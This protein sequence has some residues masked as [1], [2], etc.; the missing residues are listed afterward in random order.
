MSIRCYKYFA[1][2]ASAAD[3]AALHHQ[4][5]LA[6]DYRRVLVDIENRQRA[7]LRA[8]WA[9]PMRDIPIAERKAWRDAGGNAVI[10]AWTASDE[11]KTWR[12]TIQKAGFATCK[13]AYNAA[14]A[15]GLAW[16]TRLAVGEAVDH[17]RRTTDWVD[18]LRNT[19][20]NRVAVQIQLTKPLSGLNVVGGEDTRLQIGSEPYALGAT[21]DGFRVRATEASYNRGGNLRPRRL[22]EAKL[23]IGTVVDG[24]DPIWAA[25]HVLMHR[26]LPDGQIKGAW[27]QRHMVGGRWKWEFVVS[28]DLGERLAPV[29]PRSELSCAIDLGWRRRDNG[30]RVAY[31]IGSDGMSNEIVIPIEVERRKAKSDDLRSI[32]DKRRNEFVPRLRAWLDDHRGTWLDEALVHVAQWLRM[33]HFV[34]LERTW[35]EKRVEG[36]DRIYADLVAFLKQDRHLHAWQANNLEKMARQIRGRFDAVAHDLCAKYGLVAIED[37]RL[38]ELKEID[39]PARINARSIQKL[40]PGELLRAVKQAAGKYGTVVHEID[41]A[42]ST[43]Q[44]SACLEIRQVP[45]QSALVLTCNHCGVAEDQDRTA[46]LNLL[47]ASGQMRSD[48][49]GPLAD[50]SPTKTKKK[51]PPRRTRKK[52]AIVPLAT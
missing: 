49:G 4:C 12:S 23:R 26:P 37:L 20:S 18:D 28:I 15:A 46:A 36:D 5:K 22:R 38:T 6:G 7:L 2:P 43:L 44:C 11:Y 42:Y 27:A 21:I 35:R 19:S 31:W 45:D 40:A 32:R 47:R 13:V 29:H 30:V 24:R 41:P 17:A 51:L 52:V 16:G 33:G 8:L 9:T 34:G 48:D 3:S 14:G 39:D 25:L 1:M 10:K 50:G